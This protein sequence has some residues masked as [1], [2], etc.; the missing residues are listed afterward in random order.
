MHT[1]EC[2]LLADDDVGGLAV[3]IAARI[4]GLAGPG[5]VLI[6][7]TVRDLIAGS[8]QILADRGEHQLK[9]IAGPWRIFAV[10]T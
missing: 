1:G 7:R 5:E 2:E 6:S 4:S 3:H 8:D 9:G 10:R